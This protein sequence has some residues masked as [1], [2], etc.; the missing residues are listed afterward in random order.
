[1]DMTWWW[2][3]ARRPVR[4]PAFCGP[5]PRSPNW[6]RPVGSDIRPNGWAASVTG[7]N[8]TRPRHPARR[9]ADRRNP[10][11]D[12]SCWPP[13]TWSETPTIVTNRVLPRLESDAKGTGPAAEAAILHRSLYR[14]Q[15][16]W[17][18]R[19]PPARKL[20][21][22]FGL[23]TPGEVAARMADAWEQSET[24]SRQMTARDRRRTGPSS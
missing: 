5:R 13:R 17:I 14:N 22:L 10:G 6:F 21:Y 18:K 7:R 2:P 20:P 8:R 23:L 15:Q 11:D 16:E 1:M 9:A 3:I 12:G 4:S 24:G 19:L